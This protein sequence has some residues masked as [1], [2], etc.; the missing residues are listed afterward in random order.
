[1]LKL[2]TT[3]RTIAKMVLFSILAMSLAVPLVFYIVHAGM[4]FIRIGA[5][6]NLDFIFIF[7]IGV[8]FCK[9]FIAWFD[10]WM[11]HFRDQAIKE[12]ENEDS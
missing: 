2:S 8:F 6:S 12:L 10:S 4:Y 11:A 5:L 9:G 7:L 3:N 1:M